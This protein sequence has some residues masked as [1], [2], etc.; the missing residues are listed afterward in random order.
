MNDLTIDNA[1]LAL[2]ASV[3]GRPDAPPVLLLH[4][5]SNSRD[6]WYDWAVELSDRYRVYTLDFRGHG[7]SGRAGRYAIADYVSDAEAMLAVIGAPTHVVGH[8]LGGVVAG[9]LAQSDSA[10][11][12]SVLMLD[13]AWY[14]GIPEEFA[15]TVYPKRFA[16]LIGMITQLREAA[17]PLDAWVAAVANTPHPSGGV[18]T[19][20]MGH[21]QIMSHASA[22]Q[23]QD[24]TCWRIPVQESFAGLDTTVPFRRPTKLIRCDATLGAAFID[25]HAERI[26]TVN[27]S[28]DIVHYVG[29]DH[30]PQRTYAFAE[31]FRL[32]LEQFLRDA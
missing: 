17:A 24:P 28:L 31:R 25:A 4:G 16:L 21:R 13:P 7:H 18:F 29:S 20:H 26:R 15:R 1:G 22:L 2:A 9:A 5:I 8:S 27:P 10:L 11:V 3:Y 6:V 14:F 23:R 19:D 32:D 30:F 12:H